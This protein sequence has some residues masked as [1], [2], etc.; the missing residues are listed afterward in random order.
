MKQRPKSRKFLKPHN[1]KFSTV[2]SNQKTLS[3]AIEVTVLVATKSALM[4]MNQ[5][6]AARRVIARATRKLPNR[7][8]IIRAFPSHPQTK[9]PGETRMRRRK[10]AVERWVSVNKPGTILFELS[11]ISSKSAITI[12]KKACFKLSRKFIVETRKLS[13]N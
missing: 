3:Q 11:R 12:L 8:L 5:V 13:T 10:R 6:E 2:W 9:I 7:R 1:P 4:P